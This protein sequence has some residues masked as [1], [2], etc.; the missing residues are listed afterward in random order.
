MKRLYFGLFIGICI[1]FSTA[2]LVLTLLCSVERARLSQETAALELSLEAALEENARLRV[3]S[4][5]SL[6]LQEL[7][8][9]AREELGMQTP[10][11]GQIYHIEID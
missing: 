10:T 5:R 11:A 6:S 9:Y 3:E 1:A 8:R 7:E 2:A 4:E